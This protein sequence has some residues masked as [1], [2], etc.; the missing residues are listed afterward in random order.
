MDASP[1]ATDHHGFPTD[2]GIGSR[3]LAGSTTGALAVA[4]A[5]P[6]DVV[7]VRF[8]AQARGGGDQRYQSTVDAYKTIA[9]KEGFRGLWKG[10]YQAFLLPFLL[11]LFLGFINIPFLCRDLS[12]Y[13][14]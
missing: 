11:P 12:Q 7:K 2:A 13:C 5:Q 3:L 9:R 14:S 6:T 8:Q 4:V 10:M 1:L